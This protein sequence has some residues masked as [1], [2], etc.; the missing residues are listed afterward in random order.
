MELNHQKCQTVRGSFVGVRGQRL[1]VTTAG[2]SIGSPS[3]AAA[4][5][6]RVA[7]RP[8]CH[9][10]QSHRLHLTWSHS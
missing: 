7:P 1:R 4:A 6:Q 3:V 5:P 10:G 8:W 2:R 9:P